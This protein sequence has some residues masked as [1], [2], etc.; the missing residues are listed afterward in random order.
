MLHP[1]QEAACQRVPYQ[2]DTALAGGPGQNLLALLE[3]VNG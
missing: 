1:F 2:R 3:G